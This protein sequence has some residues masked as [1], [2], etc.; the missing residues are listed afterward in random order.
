MAGPQDEDGPH[1]V[2]VNLTEAVRSCSTGVAVPS[3]GTDDGPGRGGDLGGGGQPGGQLFVQ[4]LPI[5]GVPGVGMAGSA[6]G[7][8]VADKCS[9]LEFRDFLSL[10]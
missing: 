10:L 4:L 3:V 2:W 7:H 1:C 5:P 9:G 8:Q 6:G